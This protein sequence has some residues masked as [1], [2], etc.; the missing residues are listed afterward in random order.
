ML[1]LK[2]SIFEPR[3]ILLI[4]TIAENYKAMLRSRNLY[5]D[6]QIEAALSRIELYD[7][8]NRERPGFFDNV[9]R[10]G[11]PKTRAVFLLLASTEDI[12]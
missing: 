2:K 6:A 4:P 8:F 9:I 12:M 7:D 3:Y 5:T 10:C 11:T 1:S